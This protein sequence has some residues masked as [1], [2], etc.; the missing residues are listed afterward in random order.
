MV[1]KWSW[2]MLFCCLTFQVSA[3][4]TD[5]Q[6]M[7]DAVELDSLMKYVRQLS[8]EIP[9]VID[10]KMDTI[11]SRHYLQ[12]GNEK[13]YQFIHS[14]LLRLE[15]RVDSMVFSHSGKNISGIKSG[16]THPRQYV[17]IGAHY[18]SQPHGLIAPGADDNASGVAAL[19]EI[20]RIFQNE[21]FPYTVV[22]GFWDEEEIGLKGSIA[23]VQSIGSDNDTLLG[24][25]NLDMIG[26]DGNGDG[27]VEVNVRNVANSVKL[28]DL[29]VQNN[30]D[31]SIGLQTQVINP[32]PNS[33]DFASFWT[34]GYT[35]V[36]INEVYYGEDNN[37][38]WHT[39]AD[40][41]GH[42]NLDY[43]LKC[44]R[45]ALATVG[46]IAT[47]A[48]QVVSV[49]NHWNNHPEIVVYPNPF[50]SHIYFNWLSDG[51]TLDRVAVLD[52]SGKVM[53]EQRNIYSTFGLSLQNLASGVYFLRIETGDA[54]WMERVVKM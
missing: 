5:V 2:R 36:G 48:S 27:L 11:F 46:E 13:A 21:S 16:T 25:V 28:A 32:G 30:A 42:F 41:L 39:T 26:W 7:V 14:E 51:K 22:F 3:Q 35:A 23:Y 9:V 52:L 17:L 40:S 53:Y 50:V 31:Y 1:L 10:G 18:D 6:R 8:G 4:Q 34:R 37:P 47:N 20:A 33:S 19:L 44:T 29:V 49:R 38:Y 45:L 54:V 15:Y 12:P 43:F 24:Y